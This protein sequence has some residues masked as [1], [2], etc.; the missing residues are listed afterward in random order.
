MSQLIQSRGE[1]ACL[2]SDLANRTS[3]E[4][5]ARLGFTPVA[6]LIHLDLHPEA[7]IGRK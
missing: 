4:L 5:Y 1:Q 7:F 6:D 2:Y 3:T